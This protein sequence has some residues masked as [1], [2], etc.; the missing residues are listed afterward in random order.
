MMTIK[1]FSDNFIHM[2]EYEP[3]K[4]L[5]VDPGESEGVLQTLVSNGLDL[6]AIL[7][8][9][10]HR[11]HTAGIQ[12][13][14]KRSGCCVIGPANSRI[15]GLDREVRDGDQIRLGETVLQVI[16]T[17]GHTLDS[18]CF[19][20]DRLG[21]SG[22]VFT[23]DTLFI[24]GC[25]RLFEGRAEQLYESL[26]KLTQLPD[27]TQVYCGHN[28]TEENLRF[29]LT[30]EPNNRAIKDLLDR[31]VRESVT[32]STI[33]QEKQINIFVRS[34]CTDTLAQRRRMKDVY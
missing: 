23:G 25:G 32:V 29:G 27:Q 30:V 18:V 31:I 15:K 11:D 8:T 19:Y 14:K 28:Y 4:V 10:H 7:V 1:P 3:G 34:D 22:A 26:A 17:P 21:K 13:L 9:H 5:V 16:A 24:G 20:G 6:S 2:C 12:A 33:E